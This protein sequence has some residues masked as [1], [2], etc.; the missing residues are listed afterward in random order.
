MRGAAFSNRQLHF[1][2]SSFQRIA[3]RAAVP[4]YEPALLLPKSF[5]PV[6]SSASSCLMIFP[7]DYRS[8]FQFIYALLSEAN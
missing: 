1:V 2:K 4:V 8:K 5:C 7:R 3:R 6:M